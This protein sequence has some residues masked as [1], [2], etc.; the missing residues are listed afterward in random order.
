ML[1]FSK[2]NYVIW[3]RN[4]VFLSCCM[5]K[6]EERSTC[7]CSFLNVYLIVTDNHVTEQRVVTVGDGEG[8]V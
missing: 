4:L 1:Y 2:A 3:K 7:F 5:L 8:G 6:R